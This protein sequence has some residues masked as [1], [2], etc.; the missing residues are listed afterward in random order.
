MGPL[1]VALNGGGEFLFGHNAVAI[2]AVNLRDISAVHCTMTLTDGMFED[3]RFVQ[4]GLG[5]KVGDPKVKE[6]RRYVNSHDVKVSGIALR[7]KPWMIRLQSAFEATLC[8]VSYNWDAF[9][10]SYRKDLAEALKG[11]VQDHVLTTPRTGMQAHA[12]FD[13]R[14]EEDEVGVSLNDYH[15]LVSQTGHELEGESVILGRYPAAGEHSFR[16]TILCVLPD[17]MDGMIYLNAESWRD[18]HGGDFDGDL[19]YILIDENTLTNNIA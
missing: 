6:M 3:Q 4:A 9:F 12:G 7:L 2:P 14:I 13:P 19:A 17:Q 18:L 11:M 15:R 16:H 10:K 8:G 1:H 5:M